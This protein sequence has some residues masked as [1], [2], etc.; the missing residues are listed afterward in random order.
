[1][2]ALL[3]LVERQVRRPSGVA[4]SQSMAGPRCRV[5]AGGE[6]GC[7]IGKAFCA[8]PGS[9]DLPPYSYRGVM[10]LVLGL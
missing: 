6:A 7:E 8:G 2:L 5:G 3:W 10:R 1:M 9:W 4:P